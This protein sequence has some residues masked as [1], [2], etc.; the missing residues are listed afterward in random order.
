MKRKELVAA[1]LYVVESVMGALIGYGLYRLHPVIGLWCLFS[2]LLVLGPDKDD[3]VT[4]AVNRIKA[5]FIGASIGLILFALHPGNLL[6]ICVGV[7]LAVGICEL[8]D[9]KTATKSAAIAFL[10]VTL[11]EP[12][13]HFWDVALERAFGTFIG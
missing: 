12:G 10:I 3:A 1:L 4:V 13:K 11:H 6:A 5:N 7:G 2:I 8:M 9:L